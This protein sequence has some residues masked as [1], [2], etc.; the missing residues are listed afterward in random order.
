MGN[1][2]CLAVGE[3]TVNEPARQLLPLQLPDTAPH[4]PCHPAQGDLD[5]VY[6]KSSPLKDLSSRMNIQQ[7]IVSKRSSE[8]SLLRL[9]NDLTNM[10]NTFEKA[11]G[12]IGN[13]LTRSKITHN[14]TKKISGLNEPVIDMLKKKR[15]D[16]QT[17][18]A[19]VK[20]PPATLANQL[21]LSVEEPEEAMECSQQSHSKAQVPPAD[22]I[23]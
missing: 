22:T 16:C 19:A 10:I 20:G 14:S 13:E 1:Q 23:Q 8:A 15:G 5:L 3:A 2:C 6:A 17:E 4:T 9:N 7:A 18:E 11:H 12:T 21:A